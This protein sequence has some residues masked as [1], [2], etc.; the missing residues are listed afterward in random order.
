MVE[1]LCK[2]YFEFVVS[3]ERLILT[4]RSFPLSLIGIGRGL[5]FVLLVLARP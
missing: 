5:R 2:I 3:F 4:K 1:G